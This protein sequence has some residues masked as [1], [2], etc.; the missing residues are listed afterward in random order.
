MN[1]TKVIRF[2]F[3]AGAAILLM[4]F[5]TAQAQTMAPS[6]PSQESVTKEQ[7]EAIET[8]VREYLLKNPEVLRDAMKELEAREQKEKIE[9]AA[10]AMAA[11][12]ADI[13]SDADSPV[14][15]NPKGDVTIVVFFDYNCG[16]C[17]RSLPELQGLLDKDP[18]L[19]VIYKEF[20]ILGPQSQIAATA[21]LAAKRQGQY[22]AFN[23]ALFA[24]DG[25][26][27]A[28]LKGVSDRLKL[29]Y[30]KLQQDM[31]DPKLI[32]EIERNLKLAEALEINGTP[33][34]IVGNRIIP[35]A[36]DVDSLARLVV[37]ER[38]KIAVTKT[39]ETAAPK[40]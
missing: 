11:L 9:R 21:A 10:K 16:Y 25:A 19:K 12:K 22:S 27:D 20:P 30:A 35:G 39:A 17:K 31:A 32:A 23:H 14:A 18:M 3:V 4:A 6:K 26:G 33:A 1:T 28:M 13:Y 2:G 5:A 24:A 29:N 7:R 37:G 38:S 34:Y 36:I 15:G 40:K 8:I